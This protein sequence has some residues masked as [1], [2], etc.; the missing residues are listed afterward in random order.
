MT[1][2]RNCSQE[3]EPAGD[4]QAAMS[5]CTNQAVP[6]VVRRPTVTV[7]GH[8]DLID[9]HGNPVT[10]SAYAGRHLLVYFGFT[11]CPTVCPASIAR[12]SQVLDLLGDTA[13]TIQ[14]LYI[15]VDPERDT[16]AVMRDYLRD[17]PCILGL[18]GSTEQVEAAKAAYHVFAQRYDDPLTSGGYAVPHTALTYLMDENGAYVT[19][20]T[21][22]VT[23]Q[24]MAQGISERLERSSTAR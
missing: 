6:A 12:I 2:D 22:A 21:D 17:H 16:P 20:F 1:H 14:P 18:T 19:H 10:E 24:E 7:G 3:T 4:T 9:Y 15:S 8:F 11:H 23:A 13:S 5:C